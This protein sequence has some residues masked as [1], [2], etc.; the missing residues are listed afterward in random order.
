MSMGRKQFRKIANIIN[1]HKLGYEVVN[2]VIKMCQ[3]END[4]FDKEKFLSACY[5]GV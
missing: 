5:R 3:E 1:K 2:D 4:K